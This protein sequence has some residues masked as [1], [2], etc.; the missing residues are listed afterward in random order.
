MLAFDI[1]RCMAHNRCMR[2]TRVI[3]AIG[4]CLVLLGTALGAVP[5]QADTSVRA[6]SSSSS[7]KD[8]FTIT[9]YAVDMELGRDS[10]KRSTLKTKLTITANFPPEQNHGLAP[11]FV[12]QYKGHH[13]SFALGSVQDEHGND[14]EYSWSG[15]TLRIGNKDTY[16]SGSKTYVITYTQRDVTW[17]YGDTQKNEFY[18]DVIGTSWRVPISNATATLKLSPEL[19]AISRTTPQCYTG[20]QGSRTTCTVTSPSVDTITASVGYLAPYA[21][22]TLAVGFPQG[23]FAEYKKTPGEGFQERL[24]ALLPL[25][26]FVSMLVLGLVSSVVYWLYQRAIGRSKELGTI[27]PEYLPPPS[28]SVTTA[29]EIVRPFRMVK[30]SAMAAQMIDWAVRHYIRLIEVKPKT[31]FSRAQ[32]ELEVVKD[33]SSLHPEEQEILGDIFGHLPAVGERINLK[34]LRNNTSYAF[35]L[36]DN[37]KKLDELIDH[38]YKLRDTSRKGTRGFRILAGVLGTL[39]LLLCA[40]T[41]FVPFLSGLQFLFFPGVFIVIIIG[42]LGFAKPLSDK[43]LALRRYLLGLKMY[44]RYAEADRLRLLQSPETAEKVDIGDHAQL[45]K[46]Y[47]RVLPYAVLFGQEKQWSQQLGQYYEEVGTQPDWYAGH[48]AFNAAMFV[49][50]MSSLSSSTSV[51]SSDFSSSSGGSTGGGFSGGGGGGG[52]GGGW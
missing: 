47:E 11:E 24:E 35:R 42:K 40:A 36:S 43:G 17:N 15:N 12:T 39:V 13:T 48:G 34:T 50:S 31:F 20:K 27:V 5:M 2:T 3:S 28:T 44:I 46:L 51:G 41:M 19:A 14:Y 7:S 52:G 16:V 30:G 45:V 21:G 8:N 4:V 23:T 25:I 9:K 26:F 38:T 6:Y 29:A 32:Y 49:S 18:W 10:E 37:A 33:V 1:P 22:M